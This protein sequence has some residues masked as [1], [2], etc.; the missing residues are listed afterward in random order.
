MGRR[1]PRRADDAA[2]LDVL[3]AE[4]EAIY[5]EAEAL[6]AGWS[7]EG[8]TDCC[9][10]ER[11][12]REPY[13]TSL[14]LGYLLRAVKRSGR[15]LGAAS[16]KRAAATDAAKRTDDRRAFEAIE[17][18]GRRRLPVVSNGEG[19]CPLLDDEGRCSAYDARPIGCRTFWCARTTQT[20]PVKH[21]AM[22]ELVRRIAALA[23]RHAEG[24]DRGRPLRRA[25]EL[26]PGGRLPPRW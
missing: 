22:S 26:C 3:Y 15:A 23:A 25:I 11:T 2:G 19:R 5:A 7:C 10:F 14:E 16:S 20:H 18:D 1:D 12:G 8:S 9:H 21:R 4:L 24:G 13:V 17:A 6:Y